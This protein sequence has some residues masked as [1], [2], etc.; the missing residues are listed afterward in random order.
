MTSWIP[1]EHPFYL[2]KENGKEYNCVAFV[3]EKFFQNMTRPKYLTTSGETVYLEMFD[4]VSM[5]VRDE[6]ETLDA[7]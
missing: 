7:S 5:I 2:L 6:D 1:L 4:F 3:Q